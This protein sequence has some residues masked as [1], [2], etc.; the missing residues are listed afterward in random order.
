MRKVYLVTGALGHLGNTI[1]NS[2][3]QRKE[4]VRGFD[5][6][7]SPVRP[8]FEEGDFELLYGDITDEESVRAFFRPSAEEERIVI[9]TAGIV[10]IASK[11]DQLVRDVNVGG[12]LNILK[13]CK[14]T[15]AS[16]LVYIS[17]V[18]ALPEGKKGSVI[19]EIS[20]F[21]PEKV[22][23]LYA[24]TKAEATAAVLKA[25]KEGLNASVLHPSGIIGPFDYGRGHMTQLVVDYMNG[26]LTACVRG[27]YDF[28]DVRDVAEAAIACSEAG[29]PGE[30]YIASNRYVSVSELLNTLHLVTGRKKVKTVLPMWFAKLTAPLAEGYYK[31]LKQTPLY[32]SYS[33]YTL[34]SNALFSHEKASGELSYSPRPLKDTLKDT[35]D[36]LLAQGRVR[37]AGKK[38]AALKSRKRAAAQN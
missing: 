26:S 20:E 23:G 27:G 15:G 3:L 30:C 38:K 12:T 10:S 29:R 24:K 34:K 37:E 16:K 7:G 25:A 14:E 21:S 22:H 28:V 17:S 9:H 31:L 4:S 33:L 18:H 6:S 35:A 2:L 13:L 8:E 19:R 1:V 32:T 11:Y 36:W 5:L